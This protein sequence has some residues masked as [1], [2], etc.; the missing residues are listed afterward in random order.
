ML[1]QRRVM[2][3]RRVGKSLHA[4]VAHGLLFSFTILLVLKLHRAVR[5]PWWIVFSPLWLFHAVVARGRFSLPAPALPH[6]RNWAPFHA[7]MATPLL[8]AF[9]I[10][11]CFYLESSYGIGITLKIVFMPLLAFETAILVDN[12]R[13]C[14]ALMPGDEEAMN[15]DVIWETLPHFWV[16]ISMV[17]FIAATIFTLLKICGDVAAL[18]WWD[19][20]INFGIAEGFAFLVCTKWYN[21]SIHRHSH[22]TEP[23]SAPS[24]TMRYLDWNRGL[25]ISSEDDQNNSG[26]CDLQDIGG[27]VMK[28]PLI[29]F[30]ILLFMYL[31]GTTSGAT[32]LSIPVV[33]SPLILLQG[34]GVAFAAYRLVEKIVI[35]VHARESGRYGGAGSARYFSIASK[36]QDSFGFLHRGSRLLGW[37]SIDEGSREEQARLYSVGTSGYN[38]FSPDVVKKMPRTDLVDEIWRLQAALSEQT[39]ITKFSQQEYERLQNEKILCRVC[40][41][42]QINIVL[43]PC[44]HHVLC[45]TCCE[46]CKKCPICRVA[47]EERL[48]VYDV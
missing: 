39:E 27:H 9:E 17:F 21:P 12:I 1:V 32:H 26:I 38:T 2:T 44:R 48:P 7:V 33:F 14:R 20:F 10:L 16:S 23:S 43:L 3:W 46:K 42:E 40:F 37:W 5:C 18:G 36:V 29:I 25:V 34:A 13:M 31:E 8:V 4:L 45:R 47:I 35:L 11:L 24:I 28:V 41:E 30:Q 22:I 6:D 15:D 19:L